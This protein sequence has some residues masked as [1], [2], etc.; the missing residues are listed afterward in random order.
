MVWLFSKKPLQSDEYLELKGD[1]Q[2]LRREVESLNLDL[3]LYARKLKAAKGL[4]D[5][6][7]KEGTE[8][9]KNNV[10]LPE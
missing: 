2:K 3:Q 4:K 8:T 10:L 5:N 7:E 9:Y 1:I 6:S